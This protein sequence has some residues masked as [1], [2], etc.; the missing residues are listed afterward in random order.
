[1]K[2]LLKKAVA[3]F[4]EQLYEQATLRREYDRIKEQV[5]IDTPN[6]P[7]L[8]GYKIYSQCD[9]DGIIAHIFSRIGAG[10]RV[11]VEIGCSDGLENNS[12]ALLLNG[13]RG[14]WFDADSAKIKLLSSAL[15]PSSNLVVERN[16]V[17][18][19]NVHPLISSAL[20]RLN[21]AEIDFFSIDIDGDDV[22]VLSAFLEKMKPR[23]ICVEYNAKFPP[24][25]RIAIHPRSGSAGWRGDDYQGASLCSF[26]DMLQGF[27]YKLVCCGLSGVNA[28]F[29]KVQEAGQFP[30]FPVQ[31]LYQPARYYLRRLAS[32]HPPSLKFLADALSTNG[33]D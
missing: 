1:M 6:N 23:V 22:N 33:N 30:D 2:K 12:H 4:R 24:P 8:Y 26:A 25:M 21:V 19:S 16:F 31:R 10:G 7:A 29:V 32:G 28:F 5:A 14:A 9:E 11:F 20:Q 3:S 13:W 18:A 15:P 27:D 17:S